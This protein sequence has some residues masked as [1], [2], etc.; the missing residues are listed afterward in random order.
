M[1]GKSI[2]PPEA[3]ARAAAQSG[4]LLYRD[5]REGTPATQADRNR[6]RDDFADPIAEAGAQVVLAVRTLQAACAA[7]EDGIV[8]NAY[9]REHRGVLDQILAEAEENLELLSEIVKGIADEGVDLDQARE[10]VIRRI[11]AI[12]RLCS[13][14]IRRLDLEDSA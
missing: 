4:A 14:L 8:K 10:G 3:G 1:E 6:F 5:A 11:V 2:R 13:G 12:D 9:V 7:G